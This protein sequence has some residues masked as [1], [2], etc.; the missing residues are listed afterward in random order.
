MPS[1]QLRGLQDIQ[2]VEELC[3][4]YSMSYNPKRPGCK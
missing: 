3:L 2:D 1:Q 4:Q